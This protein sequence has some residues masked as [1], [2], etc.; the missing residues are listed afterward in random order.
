MKKAC[1]QCRL[2]LIESSKRYSER[3]KK[4][5]PKLCKDCLRIENAEKNA[6]VRKNRIAPIQLDCRS[7]ENIVRML[8]K[9]MPVTHSVI[10]RQNKVTFEE[11][12][13]ILDEARE[14]IISQ[15]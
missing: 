5:L 7:I 8:E 15:A 1:S 9:G 6:N 2:E 11:A 4:N 14:R 10:V 12:K 13:R 3:I